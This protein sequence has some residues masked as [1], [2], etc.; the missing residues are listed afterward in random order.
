MQFSKTALL[1]AIL[2][3]SIAA[4]CDKASAVSWSTTSSGQAYDL[5]VCQTGCGTNVNCILACQ[6]TACTAHCGSSTSSCFTSCSNDQCSAF[7][8][9][10]S[11]APNEVA[12]QACYRIQVGCTGTKC[13]RTL[14]ELVTLNKRTTLEERDTLTCSSS[15]GCYYDTKST[16]FCLNKSTG[17]YSSFAYNSSLGFTM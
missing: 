16:V 4:T 5:S 9:S 8:G 14:N 15:E 2:P 6:K 10:G 17:M 11:D 12:L 13:R 1:L 7:Y 3:F